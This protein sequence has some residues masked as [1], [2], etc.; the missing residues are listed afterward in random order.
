MATTRTC[1]GGSCST[2]DSHHLVFVA[3]V[4][5]LIVLVILHTHR[6]VK[7]MTAVLT[8]QSHGL[9]NQK[10]IKINHNNPNN[11]D[12]DGRH[13]VFIKKHVIAKDLKTYNSDDDEEDEEEEDM[14]EHE[15]EEGDDEGQQQKYEM[16]VYDEE[17]GEGEGKRNY[18]MTIASGDKKDLDEDDRMD[19]AM[20]PKNFNRRGGANVM[21]NQY[22]ECC[23]SHDYFNKPLM[24]NDERQYGN[25]SDNC[26]NPSSMMPL[27]AENAETVPF[28]PPGVY[29]VDL[30]AAEAG[31][32]N[33]MD[34]GK[35]I[36]AMIKEPANRVVPEQGDGLENVNGDLMSVAFVTNDKKNSLSS[37]SWI[38][39]EK[40]D[41][42]CA[43]K[44]KDS[45]CPKRRAV[46]YDA[47]FFPTQLIPNAPLHP[48]A[49]TTSCYDSTSFQEPQLFP[50]LYYETV[51]H[52]TVRS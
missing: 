33:A 44:G 29:K 18:A 9:A 7:V 19:R 38:N 10:N 16:Q 5:V 21:L 14:D 50:D 11:E 34:G 43:T 6:V 26:I 40:N 12:D 28:K 1:K 39:L 52:V 49:W 8:T 2:L 17:E 41:W 47:A 48:V 20:V 13:V 22:G 27:K 3:V 31:L 32:S 35:F 23:N 37:A 15:E 4:I 24:T 51:P 30:A 46:G 45:N 25:E 42:A 36:E